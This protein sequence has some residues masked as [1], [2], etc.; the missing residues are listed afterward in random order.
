[1]ARQVKGEAELKANLE[2]FVLGLADDAADLCW[3]AAEDVRTQVVRDIN[4]QK[5]NPDYKVPKGATGRRAHVPA[6]AGGPPNADTGNLSAR[7]TTS[8]AQRSRLQVSAVLSAGVN[9]AFNQEFGTLDGTLKPRPH[10][11]PRYHEAKPKFLSDMK[12]L[13]AKHSKR[14]GKTTGGRR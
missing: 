13:A 1:M 7:Y 14:A 11:L 4:V 6:P 3:K 12:A 10:L 8:L 5:P 2:K 9:Y